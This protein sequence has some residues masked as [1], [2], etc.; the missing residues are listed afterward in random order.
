MTRTA[1]LSA[2][3]VVAL[4][5]GGAHAQTGGTNQQGDSGGGGTASG[6][7]GSNPEANKGNRPSELP[8]MLKNGMGNAQGTGLP[9]ESNTDTGRKLISQ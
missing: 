8:N 7:K 3:M 4:V 9:A 6:S 2:A 5:A 1:V